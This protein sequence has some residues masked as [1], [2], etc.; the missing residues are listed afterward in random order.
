MAETPG[1]DQRLPSLTITSSDASQPMLL[2]GRKLWNQFVR[3]ITI[4]DYPDLSD[5][6]RACST[7][8][9][10]KASGQCVA[11]SKVEYSTFSGANFDLESIRWLTAL[12]VAYEENEKEVH[13]KLDSFVAKEKPELIL[14]TTHPISRQSAYIP[15]LQEYD[16]SYCP[17]EAKDLMPRKI[18]KR[19]SLLREDLYSE[20]IAKVSNS[21]EAH[22]EDFARKYLSDYGTYW[23]TSPYFKS[24]CAVYQKEPGQP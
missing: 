2:L 16:Y 21:L 9:F 8:K 19:T 22:D 6:L 18:F 12:H 24:F 14:V 3:E 4:G 13:Q 10:S 1:A 20:H 23:V 5:V 7:L 15:N 17:M 11:V